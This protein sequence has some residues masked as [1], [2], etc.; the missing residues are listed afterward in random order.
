MCLTNPVADK[1]VRHN[2]ELIGCSVVFRSSDPTEFKAR[3]QKIADHLESNLDAQ[4]K[5]LAEFD[6]AFK[7]HFN[8]EM[9]GSPHAAIGE[10]VK[11]MEAI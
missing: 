9:G 4:V 2:L 7:L 6:S 11:R 8:T 1:P 5:I 3:F 10:F